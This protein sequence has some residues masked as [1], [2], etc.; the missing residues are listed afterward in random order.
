M[1]RP[2]QPVLGGIDNDPGR[3]DETDGLVAPRPQR[4]SDAPPKDMPRIP[5]PERRHAEQA[6]P[7]PE[8]ASGI[9]SAPEAPPAASPALS[10]RGPLVRAPS[11]GEGEGGGLPVSSPPPA[12]VG[13]APEQGRLVTNHLN[14]FHMLA[15][16]LLLPRSGFG[17][18]YY[19]DT[20]AACPGWIPLFTGRPPRSAVDHSTAEARHL[21]P[22]HVVVSLKDCAGP[23]MVAT[24]SGVERRLW[25]HVGDTPLVFVPAP[26]PVSA[27]EEIVFPSR[28]DVTACREAAQDYANV[29]LDDFKTRT[30][31][32]FAT[33]RGGLS[34]PPPHV[35]PER[36]VPLAAA[37]AAGGMLAMLRLL[38]NR[39]R[40]AI[41]DGDDSLGLV[42]C[43]AG[44]DPEADTPRSV[45]GT[46]AGLV[47]WMRP[48]P[49]TLV[50]EEAPLAV[51]PSDS[52]RLF[53][54][55]VD[56]LAERAGV[57]G[58]DEANARLLD[59][60][61]GQAGDLDERLR[62]HVVELR[63]TLA[64]LGGLA[65]LTV[66]DLFSR[67]RTPFPRA[68][69]LLFLRKTC[70][71]LLDF[72][73][74][75]LSDEDRLAAAL[76]FG[77]RAGWLTLPL[78]LRGGPV[79]SAAISHR[80]AALSH[81]RAESSF[82][83]GPAPVRPKSLAELFA[84]EWTPRHRGAALELVR[85]QKWAGCLETRVKLGVGEY[86]LK[87]TGAGTEIVFPGEARAVETRVDR[88]RFSKS[89]AESLV[90]PKHEAA[91]AEMLPDSATAQPRARHRGEDRRRG[92]DRRAAE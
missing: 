12:A 38:A 91:I 36:D 43:R 31:R 68:M 37:Q 23:A 26:L 54:G 59:Y 84:G 7:R 72:R 86:A 89:L 39:D 15:S 9:G 6:A 29:S 76:L 32:T 10:E 28:G 35:P 75:A 22:C 74:D 25:L 92:G 49:S 65:D 82:T 51:N 48:G 83:M 20:L 79:A 64:S 18:K 2:K 44:F 30:L 11:R 87:V 1:D 71:E 55:A 33:A 78:A 60:L 63:E 66:S 50:P 77:A 61:D 4:V 13:T 42:A 88:A 46:A 56:T 24:P 41:L 73:H 80:M 5:T 19:Q 67:F 90:D 16:G 40:A 17:G 14:L 21:R 34:W 58:V 47:A 81:L 52:V 85:R 53:R 27:I 62:K 69:S 70:E 45:S 3:G 8:K 57:A